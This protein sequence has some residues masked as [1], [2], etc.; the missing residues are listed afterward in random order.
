MKRVA[1]ERLLL[2]T[3]VLAVAA[4]SGDTAQ[5]RSSPQRHW[6]ETKTI[7]RGRYTNC[8][9]GYYVM[10]SSGVIAHGSHSPAPNHG[11]LVSLPDVGKASEASVSDPRFLWV[12]AEYNMS[13]SHSL[14]G[15]AD[16][17]LNLTSSDKAA[18]Q[19]AERKST[20]LGGIAAVRLRFEYGIPVGGDWYEVLSYSSNDGTDRVASGKPVQ[21]CAFG[22][23]A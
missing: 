20:T 22:R 15:V 2:S 18:L 6:E 14:R 7:W 5:H 11:F 9:Y 4:I 10:R 23:A 19:I 12:N 21:L 1:L 13:E 8:K 17:K 16:Y 3:L